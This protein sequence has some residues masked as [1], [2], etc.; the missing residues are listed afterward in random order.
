MKKIF[1][2]VLAVICFNSYAGELKS[3]SEVAK[4]I[5]NGKQLTW[6]WAIKECTSEI[7]LP[8]VT[9]AVRPNAVM[10]ISNE[11]ITASDRHFTLNDPSLP[12]TPAFAY[13]KY[14]LQSNGQALLSITLMQAKD[15]SKVKSYKIHCELGKGLTVFD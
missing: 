7:D 2:T 15:Y 9:T 6:V 5:T 14:N 12:D 3:F 1:I 10:L 4:A 13:S 11:R 8:D